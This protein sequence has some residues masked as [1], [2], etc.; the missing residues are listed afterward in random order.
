MNRLMFW[1]FGTYGVSVLHLFYPADE[2]G[3]AVL[4]VDRGMKGGIERVKEKQELVGRMQQCRDCVAVCVAEA[5]VALQ[6]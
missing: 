6:M 5:A 3:S 4:Q 1:Q 2:L